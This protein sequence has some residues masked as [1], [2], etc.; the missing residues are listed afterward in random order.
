MPWSRNL[1]NLRDI[2]AALYFTTEDARQVTEDAGL[3]TAYIAFSNKS[4]I[5]WHAIL[6]EAENQGAVSAILDIA[7]KRYP[8]HKGL[9]DLAEQGALAAVESPTIGAQLPWRA[10]GS[11][12]Q[13]EKIVGGQSTLLPIHFLEVGLQRSRAVARVVLAD[14]SLASGFLTS[15]NLL[16]T[17]HHVLPDRKMARR[18]VVQFNY[19]LTANGL[20]ASMEEFRLAPDAVFATSPEEENDWTLIRVAGEPCARWGALTLRRQ[21]VQAGDFVNIIQHPMGAPKQIAL[22]HNVVVFAGEGRVQYLTDTEPGSSGSPVFNSDWQV[23]AIHHSG[24]WLTE[25]GTRTQ[26]FRNEGIHVD[27]LV[28]GLAAAGLYIA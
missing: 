25:P 28:D 10:R 8:N 9:L 11:P 27:R 22:Y 13:W 5:T 2:L 26:F 20:S 15:D 3:N 17:N 21:P 1:A 16:V 24:G 23:V 19:Q 12:D 14:G 18:A 4:A 6:T 7:R